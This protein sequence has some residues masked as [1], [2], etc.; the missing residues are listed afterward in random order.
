MATKKNTETKRPSEP[1]ATGQHAEPGTPENLGS[2]QPYAAEPWPTTTD[3][4]RRQRAGRAPY[5]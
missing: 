1:K 4:G 5:L 3:R 2:A